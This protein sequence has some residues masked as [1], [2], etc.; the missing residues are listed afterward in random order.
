MKTRIHLL[1]FFILLMYSCGGT[2]KDEAE[3]QRVTYSAEIIDGVKYIHNFDAIWG[4]DPDVSLKFTL[5]IG[6]LDSKDENYQFFSPADITE[7][8]L[9]NIYVLDAGNHRIQKFDQIGNYIGTIGAKGQGPGE[10][11]GMRGLFVDKSGRLYVTDAQLQRLKVLSPEGVEINSIPGRYIS[12]K[13]LV[14]ES[15]DIVS[16][17]AGKYTFGRMIFPMRILDNSGNTI[18]EFGDVEEHEV[19]EH[20]LYFNLITFT[21]DSEENIVVAHSTRNKVQKYSKDGALL[22]TADRPLGYEI[23]M[24]YKET[25]RQF[26]N[27]IFKIPEINRVGLMSGVDNTDRIWILSYERQLTYEEKSIKL[28]IANEQGGGLAATENL[29]DSKSI[30]IDA[31]RFHIFDGEGYFLGKIPLPDYGTVMK[32]YGDR[33]YLIDSKYEMCVYQYRIVSN[34]R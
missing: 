2:S 34:N 3:E 33:M 17:G 22:F 4:N 6:E 13:I 16:A 1:S 19:W 30:P 5:K 32:I 31:Y 14:A 9:G 26:G 11:M 20:Y 29:K 24:E 12:P 21:F 10:F 15:G 25:P 18:S 7:D 27:R 28:N 23:T 8:R